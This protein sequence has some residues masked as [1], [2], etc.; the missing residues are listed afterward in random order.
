MF[1]TKFSMMISHKVLCMILFSLLVHT[2]T[3]QDTSGSSQS[4]PCTPCCGTEPAGI[5]GIPGTPGGPG[6]DGRDG[7]KGDKGEGGLNGTPGNKGEP[8]TASVAPHNIKQCAWENIND[9]RDAGIVKECPFN[10]MFSDTALRVVWNGNL[11]VLSSTGACN[12]WSFTFN[13]NECSDP[14]P[15]D[16]AI[17]NHQSVNSLRASQVEGLCYGIPAGAVKLEFR[18]GDC[19]SSHSSGDAYTGWNSASRIIVEEIQVTT[20]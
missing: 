3:S 10:K 6:R 11:R 7:V 2:G 17:Y 1:K 12:R 8:G 18:V 15:I 5:P 13:G 19:Q 14:L 4:Q 20:Q 16:T 9:D